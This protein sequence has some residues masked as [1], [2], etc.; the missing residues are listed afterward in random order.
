MTHGFATG[1]LHKHDLPTLHERC[2]QMRLVIMDE[3]VKGLV[4]AIPADIEC[5][6]SVLVSAKR[7]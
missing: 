2:K 3:T 7:Q 4:P 5:F 1:L 6:K